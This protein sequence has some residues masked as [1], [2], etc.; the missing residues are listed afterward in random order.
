MGELAARVADE[1]YLE[2]VV[3]FPALLVCRA[4]L[5]DISASI[6]HRNV[7]L[8]NCINLSLSYHFSFSGMTK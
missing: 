1:E 3:I 6:V 5:L 2:I 8:Y 4:F 7:L